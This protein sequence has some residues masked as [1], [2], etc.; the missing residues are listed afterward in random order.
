VIKNSGLR[1]FIDQIR[2]LFRSHTENSDRLLYENTFVKFEASELK[3]STPV[4]DDQITLELKKYRFS[5]PDKKPFNFY[6]VA[7]SFVTNS[8][9]NAFLKLTFTSEEKA[10]RFYSKGAEFIKTN[11]TPGIN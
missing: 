1:R 8:Y 3:Y 5:P 2:K 10:G 6:I 9:Y 11:V 4:N 7:A